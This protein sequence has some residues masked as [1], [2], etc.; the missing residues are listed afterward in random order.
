MYCERKKR[1]RRRQVPLKPRSTSRG[2]GCGWRSGLGDDVVMVGCLE[3]T[4]GA[5]VDGRGGS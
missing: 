1:Y 3:V 5:M 4:R 2:L